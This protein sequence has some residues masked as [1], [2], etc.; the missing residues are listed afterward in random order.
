M[1]RIPWYLE[2]WFL[3]FIGDQLPPWA[4][5]P[6]LLGLD[7]MERGRTAGGT[8]RSGEG[9]NEKPP[10]MPGAGLGRLGGIRGSGRGLPPPGPPGTEA[11]KPEL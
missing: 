10:G 8:G 6:C 1:D 11:I 9:G 5:G 4:V 2:D 3:D 7:R